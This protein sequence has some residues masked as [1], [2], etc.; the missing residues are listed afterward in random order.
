MAVC[1]MEKANSIVNRLAEE[2]RLQVSHIFLAMLVLFIM[3]TMMS[4]R[5]FNSAPAVV[6]RF[7]A[8]DGAF[9]RTPQALSAVVVDE[10]HLVG[11]DQRGFLL[12]PMLTKLRMV[13][14]T[15]VQVCA[16][17]DILLKFWWLHIHI[18]RG[19]ADII[20]HFDIDIL[21]TTTILPVHAPSLEK[22]LV[23]GWLF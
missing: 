14:P 15:K 2:T 12:E 4:P 20:F 5:I 7:K 17:V 6:P 8:L 21:C 13:C 19:V 3:M 9:D 18:R 11:D 16:A 10:M 1:T 23:F 22:E